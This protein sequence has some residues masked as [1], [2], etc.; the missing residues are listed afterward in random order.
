[1]DFVDA[2]SAAANAGALAGDVIVSVDGAPVNSVATLKKRLEDW[3]SGDVVPLTVLRAGA[4]S[5]VKVRLP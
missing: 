5:F 4:E 2:G 1:M 3:K